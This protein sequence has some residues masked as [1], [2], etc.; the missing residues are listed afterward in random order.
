VHGKLVNTTGNL[1]R[2]IEHRQKYS[3]LKPAEL[4][5]MLIMLSNWIVA[6][7]YCHQE[8]NIDVYIVVMT[9]YY[10]DRLRT[11]LFG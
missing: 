4:C 3:G 9:T 2:K 11:V 7:E 10:L 1:S 8:I 5:F 6:K